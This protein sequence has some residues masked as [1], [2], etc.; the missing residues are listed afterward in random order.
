MLAD[1]PK[2]DA[3]LS[4]EQ[5]ESE[6]QAVIEL[7]S[8]VRNIRAEMNIKPSDKPAIHIATNQGLQSIFKSNEAQILKLARAERL[9]LS[10]TLDVPKASAKAVLTGGAEIAVPL[11]GLIDFDKERERLENQ[12]NKLETENERLEKQLS[13]QNFVER[14]PQEKVQELRERIAEIKQQTAT[15]KQNLEALK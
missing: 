2:G 15:L 9:N 8:K 7:I 11:E 3:N 12:I 13:N 5:A 4:D 6:M 1:F 14:A 10:E